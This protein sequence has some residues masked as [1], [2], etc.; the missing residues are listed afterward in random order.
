M[1]VV[2]QQDGYVT[3]YVGNES[4]ADVYFDDVSVPLGQGLQVQETEYDPVGLELAGLVAPAPGIQGLN[5]YRFN[6]KEFQADLGLNWNHQDWRFFN[7]QI[8]TWSVVDPEVENEQESISPYAFSYDNAVRYA[9]AN[10]RCPTCPQG[11]AADEVYALGATINSGGKTYAY[12]G[13]GVYT[14]TQGSQLSGK[15]SEIGGAVSEAAAKSDAFAHSFYGSGNEQAFGLVI[16]SARP[17][18]ISAGGSTAREIQKVNG[19]DF[20]EMMD[21][22][23][24]PAL[25]GGKDFVGF[26]GFGGSGGVGEAVEGGA[27]LA[28]STTDALNARKEAKEGAQRIDTLQVFPAPFGKPG[29]QVITVQGNVKS[30]TFTTKPYSSFPQKYK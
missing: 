17:N 8:F 9:D 18:G 11:K 30:N 14:E 2:A 7:P 20:Q 24:G 28:N 19:E 13:K 10:G 12:G 6:G 3:A 27:G 4:N 29:A 15:L 26:K 16:E 23:T 25:A 21:L 22:L 5:N 1:Q